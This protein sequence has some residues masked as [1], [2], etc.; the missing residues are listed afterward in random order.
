MGKGFLASEH[1]ELDDELDD[2]LVDELDDGLDD[3]LDEMCWRG[4]QLRVGPAGAWD[5]A[6]ASVPLSPHYTVF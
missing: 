3:E 1:L 4:Q 6:P 5:P 2:E